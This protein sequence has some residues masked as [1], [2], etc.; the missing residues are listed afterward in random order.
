MKSNMDNV[1]LDYIADSLN[2]DQLKVLVRATNRGKKDKTSEICL[3][4]GEELIS[5]KDIDLSPGETKPSILIMLRD[6][7]Y[8]Y[9][10]N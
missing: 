4:G 3:Y 9:A 1:S 7:E 8:I 6:K 5:V 10:V 2:E